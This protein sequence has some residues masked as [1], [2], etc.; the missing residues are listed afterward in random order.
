V[1]YVVE[2]DETLSQEEKAKRKRFLVYRYNPQDPN[3]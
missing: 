2:H 1:N 3:D